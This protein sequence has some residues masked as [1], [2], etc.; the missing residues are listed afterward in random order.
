MLTLCKYW[1][2]RKS[3]VSPSTPLLAIKQFLK[4]KVDA[5]ELLLSIVY[6]NS[7]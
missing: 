3:D 5:K 4:R 7:P 6:W 1:R 2:K